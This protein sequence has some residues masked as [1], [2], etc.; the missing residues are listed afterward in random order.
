MCNK[1][2]DASPPEVI[3]PTK[4]ITELNKVLSRIDEGAAK[5]REHDEKGATPSNEATDASTTGGWGL[6]PPLR[7]EVHAPPSQVALAATKKPPP[8]LQGAA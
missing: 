1:K 2:E 6:T 4:A 5:L 8:S 7:E 3:N